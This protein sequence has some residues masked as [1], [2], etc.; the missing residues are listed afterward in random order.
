V[1]AVFIQFADPAMRGR[2]FASMKRALRP[3]GILVLLGYNPQQLVY[4]TGGPGVLDH[5]YTPDLL[6]D[7]FGDLNILELESFEESL[8]EGSGHCGQSA[9][10]GLVA[11]A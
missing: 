4:K 3:G 5:L 11:R 2:L 6:I 7:A 8:T 10:I 9:L 1:V